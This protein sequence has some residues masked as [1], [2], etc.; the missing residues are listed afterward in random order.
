MLLMTSGDAFPAALERAD[1]IV[2]PKWSDYRMFGQQRERETAAALAT[3]GLGPEQITFLGYPDEG[4]CHLAST[5]LFDKT[6]AF[7]SPYS[8]RESPP[9]TEQLIRGARYRGVDV[10]REIEQVITSFMPTLIVLPDIDDNHPDHCSTQIFV[11]EALE[12]V[13]GTLARRVRTLHY[14][15]HYEGWPLTADAGAGSGSMLRPP[16][17]FPVS[18]G[19]WVS[20][21]LTREEAAG[22]K[23][24]LRAYTTQMQVLGPFMAAFGRDNELFVEGEPASRAQCWCDDENVAIASSPP[25]AHRLPNRP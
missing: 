21:A 9:P 11:H 7:Q 17:D 22:K 18:D 12:A 2:Q 16:S 13:P 14:L 23:R 10:R 24:A 4:L 19:R 20:L 25:K 6:R 1:G 5:Y 15:V 3:L 8:D